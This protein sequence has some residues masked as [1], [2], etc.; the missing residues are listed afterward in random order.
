MTTH[1]L[2]DLTVAHLPRTKVGEL[3]R[4]SWRGWH[5]D[6]DGYRVTVPAQPVR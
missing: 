5:V 4:L 3:T 1:G 2:T 6:L